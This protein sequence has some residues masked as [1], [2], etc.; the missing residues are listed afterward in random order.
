M[1][2]TDADARNVFRAPDEDIDSEGEDIGWTNE[3]MKAFPQLCSHEM[4][5]ALC[6]SRN[7]SLA[8]LLPAAVALGLRVPNWQLRSS[9][10][11]AAAVFAWVHHAYEYEHCYAQPWLNRVDIV[12]AISAALIEAGSEPITTAR[13]ASASIAAGSWLWQ[14]WIPAGRPR[15]VYAHVCWHLTSSVVAAT[16]MVCMHSQR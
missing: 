5:S 15:Q 9:G 10:F 13:F 14:K 12:F 4:K 6:I 11:A 2:W 16:A 3:D 1:G 7:T 8:Y